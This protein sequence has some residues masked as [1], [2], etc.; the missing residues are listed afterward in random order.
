MGL[1]R[2]ASQQDHSFDSE[3]RQKSK[4]FWAMFILEKNLSLQ[5][6]RSSTLRDHDITVPLRA[7]KMGY[8]IGGSLGVLSPKWLRISQIEG[9][10]YDEI[11]SPEALHQGSNTRNSRARGLIADMKEIINDTDPYESE[12]LQERRRVLG[13]TIDDIL[14][15]CDKISHLSLMTLLS[16]TF[17]PFFVIIC[18]A[19]WTLNT[20]DLELLGS[21]VS[22]LQAGQDRDTSSTNHLLKTFKPLYNAAFK[23]IEAKSHSTSGAVPDNITFEMAY[24][25]TAP[26][27]DPVQW[28]NISALTSLDQFMSHSA[29]S[30]T[31]ALDSTG[32]TDLRNS[33]S[34]SQSQPTGA[35]I[36]D[37]N[38]AQS[39]TAHQ[40][41]EA[42]MQAAQLEEWFLQS[43]HVMDMME[44]ARRDG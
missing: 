7:I 20:A 25:Q 2:I 36:D 12:F 6:G 24:H 32:F 16:S 43:R 44:D 10:V 19:I 23:Y 31:M 9:R 27:A 8:Q 26:V 38:L 5:L 18:N 29:P 14:I 30:T 35:A 34:T 1:H 28:H 42:R 15:Q 40:I 33:S 37:T 21:L 17:V 4:L 39:S 13:N 41:T 22:S 11:Y 3:T